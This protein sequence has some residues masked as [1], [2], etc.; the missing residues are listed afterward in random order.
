MKKIKLLAGFLIVL[1]TT[2]CGATIG[3][4]DAHDTEVALAQENSAP[5]KELTID[6]IDT[7]TPPAIPLETLNPI[8]T[9]TEIWQEAADFVDG[10]YQAIDHGDLADAWAMENSGFQD[11]STNGEGIGVYAAFWTT[12]K[13]AY[14][15][16]DCS[17]VQ[18]KIA[19]HLKHFYRYDTEYLFPRPVEY[20]FEY[21][22]TV[23]NGRW[24]IYS[25]ETLDVKTF[26]DCE[27]FLTF[28]KP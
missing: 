8:S 9:S 5:T 24:L 21:T 17:N 1:V 12:F 13:P 23:V 14:E 6:T 16:A 18:N 7:D 11:S 19:V 15:L 28:P 27:L 10:F 4:V 20:W 26:D 22:L 2:S 3:I 25:S